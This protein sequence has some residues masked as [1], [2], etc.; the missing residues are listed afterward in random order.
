MAC[1][2]T[3]SV[4]VTA[5]WSADLLCTIWWK[6]RRILAN[7]RQQSPS[8]TTHRARASTGGMNLTFRASGARTAGRNGEVQR[9][10]TKTC[11]DP[12]WETATAA[13]PQSS[14]VD[15]STIVGE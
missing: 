2:G 15:E 1:H 4:V 5:T 3:A 11:T 9:T 14:R 12:S 8:S 6:G 13:P 7:L 10:W